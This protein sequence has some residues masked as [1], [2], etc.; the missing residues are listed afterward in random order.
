[1]LLKIPQ[2]CHDL[3]CGRIL[4]RHIFHLL[5]FIDGEI[6]I[7]LYDFLPRHEEPVGFH[8][9][10]PDVVCS[11]VPGLCKNQD[12]SGDAGIGFEHAGGHGDYSLKALILNQ[13]LSDRFMSGGR[14]EQYTVRYDAGTPPAH[15][16]HPYE[17]CEEQKLCFLCLADLQQ[18]RRYRV[19]IQ[20]TLEGRVC[21][22][23]AVFLTVWIL[24]G[25]T[26][27]VFDK[28]IVHAVRRSIVR[29]ISKPWNM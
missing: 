20:R 27:T 28:R 14:A 5:I 12:S 24:V 18:V 6:V 29:S 21:Q 4:H 25:K 11:A 7:I 23:Q 10:E 3:L 26:V 16:Q 15:L 17:Q 8:V 13:L 2:L 22:A 9:I 19:I 1:M